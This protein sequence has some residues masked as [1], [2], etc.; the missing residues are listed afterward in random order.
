LTR[1]TLLARPSRKPSHLIILLSSFVFPI[2][3]NMPPKAAASPG[4]P[5]LD[6]FLKFLLPVLAQTEVEI[7]TTKD[8]GAT[9][10]AAAAPDDIGV[11]KDES[12]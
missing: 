8:K 2:H 10:L 3:I 5:G 1:H 7:K 6:P 11:V 9:A 12:N 4:E